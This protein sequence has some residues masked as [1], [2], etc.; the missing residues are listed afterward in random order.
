MIIL[1]ERINLSMFCSLK[2]CKFKEIQ[3]LIES[4]INHNFF[5][6]L[7]NY[8]NKNTSVLSIIHMYRE[9]DDIIEP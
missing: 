3:F 5:I 9:L 8:L 7:C 6:N 4:V 2:L 1:S